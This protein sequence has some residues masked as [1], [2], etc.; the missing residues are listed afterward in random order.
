MVYVPKHLCVKI[1]DAVDSEDVSFVTLGAI[2]LQGIRQSEPRLGNRIAVIGLGLLGR[3]MVRMLKASGC[4]LRGSDLDASKLELA[5]Q[6]GADAVVASTGLIEAV[7]TFSDGHGVDTVIITASTVLV[8][9]PLRHERLRGDAD[10]SR[11]KSTLFKTAKRDK[12]LRKKW[13]S[14]CRP[15]NGAFLRSSRSSRLTPSPAP[16][17]WQCKA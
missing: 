15:S 17:F 2:A 3:F 11:G 6:L 8:E 4:W 12:D 1:Q 9:K 14:L 16:A 5:R 7:A 13:R 10:L